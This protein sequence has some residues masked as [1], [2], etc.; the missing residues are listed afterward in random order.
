M[1]E[2]Q[3]VSLKAFNTFGIDLSTQTLIRIYSVDD[4]LSFISMGKRPFNIIGGGSNVLLTRDQECVLKNEIKGIHIV[5]EDEHHLIVRVGAG[6]EWHQLVLWSLSHHLGGLENLSLIPGSAGA[7]PMQNI[8]AYGVEQESVFVGLDAV[9]LQTGAIVHFGKDDCKF[10]YRESVFKHDL[11]GRYFIT[12]VSY[13]LSKKNHILHLEYGAIKDLLQQQKIDNPDIRDVSNAVI[14]IRKSKL[15]D[16]SL[17][18][19]AGSFFKNP[20]ISD[21]LF[22]K[23]KLQFPDI[24]SYRQNDGS[25]KI[26]AGWL[27]ERAG[28][29]GMRH[30]GIGVHRDQA[31]VLVNYG[32][33]K[34]TDIL[35][36]AKEIQ[37]KI[38]KLFNIELQ[39]EVNIW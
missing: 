19:N 21:S 34:G 33:G 14:A 2:E 12:H 28:F 7:A 20:V 4:V 1:F 18:G 37:E 5:S 9:D 39:P 30:G 11:K 38:L 10:G 26:P 15:P 22:N 27:I 32:G 35:D 3:S 16:P 8:G 23:L 31:L 29:K 13:R 25:V 17:I 36:L 24:V 6:E